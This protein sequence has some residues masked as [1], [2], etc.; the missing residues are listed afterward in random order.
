MLY[1]YYFHLFLRLTDSHIATI[2]RME[3]ITS[4]KSEY[5]LQF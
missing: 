3:F 4:E 5:I 1:T 2:K